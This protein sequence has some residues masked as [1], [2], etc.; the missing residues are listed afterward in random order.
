MSLGY[1]AD[2]SEA[3]RTCVR[4]FVER[5]GSAY[6]VVAQTLMDTNETL[7]FCGINDMLT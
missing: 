6:N 3:V 2:K 1:S 5:E 7:V 4:P